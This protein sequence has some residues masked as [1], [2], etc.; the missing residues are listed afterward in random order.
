MIGYIDI[1]VRDVH[2]NVMM[3]RTET[4]HSPVANWGKFLA[5]AIFVSPSLVG[6]NTERGTV[7][8][9]SGTEQP[10][11][12]GIDDGTYLWDYV[13]E[14]LW[15]I[16]FGNGSSP[17]FD[18]GVYALQNQLALVTPSDTS[19]SIT[20]DNITIVFSASYSPSQDVNI[21]ELGLVLHFNK[22]DDL[23]TNYVDALMFYDVLE[24]PVSVPAG[25]VITV[26]YRLVFP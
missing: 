5:Y 3:R 22:F 21:T 7:V 26:T 2:G 4:L 11:G 15:R 14:P 8:D 18:R 1:E 9:L 6:T 12:G 17:S 20:A 16:A 25:G 13:E 10:I 23:Y 24:T 19:I